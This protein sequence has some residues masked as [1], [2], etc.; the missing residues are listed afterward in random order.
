MR[1]VSPLW[2]WS[3]EPTSIFLIWYLVL[4]ACSSTAS[5]AWLIC[6]NSCCTLCSCSFKDRALAAVAA[7]ICCDVIDA[8]PPS[9]SVPLGAWARS[10]GAAICE[11]RMNGEMRWEMLMRNSLSGCDRRGTFRGRPANW[12][13]A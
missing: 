3:I 6:C 8:R 1:S 12:P 11:E 10:A 5:C 4:L 2:K 13:P 9:W 7:S